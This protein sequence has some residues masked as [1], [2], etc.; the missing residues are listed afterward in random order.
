MNNPKIYFRVTLFINVC[1]WLAV[2]LQYLIHPL[3]GR[4]VLRT[5]DT[6]FAIFYLL[7]LF[8]STVSSFFWGGWLLFHLGMKDRTVWLGITFGLISLSLVGLMYLR[9]ALYSGPNLL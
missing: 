1:F 3:G 2:L 5:S 9:L 7:L 6:I 4:G 8:L